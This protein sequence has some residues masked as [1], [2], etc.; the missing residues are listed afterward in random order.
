MLKLE[1]KWLEQD[2][3]IFWKAFFYSFILPISNFLHYA[4][5]WKKEKVQIAVPIIFTLWT[6]STWRHLTS[7]INFP[8]NGWGGEEYICFS[9]QTWKLLPSSRSWFFT[10]GLFSV[11]IMIIVLEW[12]SRFPLFSLLQLCYANYFVFSILSF[13]FDFGGKI[14]LQHHVGDQLR[15]FWS[16]RKPRQN[17]IGM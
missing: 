7:H 16:L 2:S 1:R 3:K 4:M 6:P 9:S 15:V 14:C 10:S 11:L 17:E 12:F 13:L 5:S 8:P